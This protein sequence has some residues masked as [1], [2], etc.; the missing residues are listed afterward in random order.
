[1]EKG[2]P[3]FTRLGQ[4]ALLFIRDLGQ[5]KRLRI[6]MQ[7]LSSQL[8]QLVYDIGMNNGQDTAFYLHQ[9]MRVLAIEA[10]PVLCEEA[11]GRFAQQIRED[12][13]IILNVGITEA[14][15]EARFYKSNK[16]SEW[17][18]FSL[19]IANRENCGYTEIRVRTRRFA[20]IL[21]DHGMPVYAKIDIEGNDLL[22]LQDMAAVG[23]PGYVSVETEC[24][25][26]TS[27]T[28][29]LPG[30]T[31]LK[32]LH[33]LGYRY[34]KLVD[35][36]SLLPYEP[37]AKWNQ[38]FE[39]WVQNTKTIS[40]MKGRFAQKWAQ[41]LSYRS[42]LSRRNH[43][44]FRRGGSGPWGEGIECPWISFEQAASFYR[45]AS[46]EHFSDPDN[47]SYSLWFDW[48]AKKVL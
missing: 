36:D 45:A 32:M 23:T 21:K 8:A 16:Y 37:A 10:D 2:V 1:L 19:E 22:C 38:R 20:D 28:D 18:S 40:F 41:R 7:D 17:N 3:L 35:Q 44:Y 24:L 48:H 5:P 26:D 11:T 43:F 39:S 15:G 12:R 30:L 4:E 25:G 42:R 34:F 33:N 13:L 6:I 14:E 27:G 29:E 47:P 9:G 46:R 31:T